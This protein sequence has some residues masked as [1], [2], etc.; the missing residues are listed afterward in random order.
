MHLSLCI[1]WLEL[2][3]NRNKDTTQHQDISSAAAIARPH[4]SQ[5]YCRLSG[6]ACAETCNLSRPVFH[7]PP[8]PMHGR[9]VQILQRV[10]TEAVKPT[11]EEGPGHPGCV[12]AAEPLTSL[13]IQRVHPC[14][15]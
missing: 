13:D 4:E 2:L 5:L 10:L 1:P 15:L 12:P 14:A 11:D 3:S 7:Q 8:V 9:C 6:P